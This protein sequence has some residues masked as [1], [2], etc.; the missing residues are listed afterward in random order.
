LVTV[1]LLRAK[2]E[3]PKITTLKPHSRVEVLRTNPN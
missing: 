1:N 3:A 2:G